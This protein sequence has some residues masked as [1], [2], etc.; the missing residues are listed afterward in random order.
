MPTN[1]QEYSKKY[2]EE[3]KEHY[4]QYRIEN[5]E[6]LNQ[7]AREWYAKNKAKHLETKRE[8]RARGKYNKDY[9]FFVWHEPITF[10]FD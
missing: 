10:K 1:R 6:M 5:R 3:H 4:I 9:V 8:Y 7:R 2:M